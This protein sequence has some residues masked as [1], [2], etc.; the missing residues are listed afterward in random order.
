[1]VEMQSHAMTSAHH[2]VCMFLHGS[3]I[4]R[5]IPP[6]PILVPRR[7]ANDLLI[8]GCGRRA[9]WYGRSF[10]LA[11]RLELRQGILFFHGACELQCASSCVMVIL[12]M[13]RANVIFQ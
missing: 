9:L 6:Q 11:G 4:Q 8:P 2:V 10:E 7:Q 1:M 5:D 13:K 12:S 3:S